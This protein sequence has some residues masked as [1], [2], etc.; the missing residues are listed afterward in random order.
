VRRRSPVGK[1]LTG[2]TAQQVLLDANCP[3]L[4]VKAPGHES[5]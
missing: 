1:V 2:S 4:A 3:V 5:G